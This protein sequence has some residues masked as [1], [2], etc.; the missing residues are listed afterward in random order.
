[1]ECTINSYLFYGTSFFTL[2]LCYKTICIKK[3]TTPENISIIHTS[4]PVK[5][6]LPKYEDIPPPQ[7][8]TI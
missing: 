5:A 1:M 6:I 7:Y 2:L 3:T 4:Q 8:S